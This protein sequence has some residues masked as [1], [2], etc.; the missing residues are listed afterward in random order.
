MP[1]RVV[2]RDKATGRIGT[3]VHPFEVPDLSQFRVTTPVLSDT[4]EDTEQGGTGNRLAIL[5]R[6]D[7]PEGSSLFCQVEVYGA[8]RLESSR[9]PD[10]VVV[11]DKA[12]G[13]IGT[14]VH[15]FEVPDL[16]QFRVKTPVLSDTREDTEQGGTGNRLAI[17]AR[18][19]FPEG[20]SLFCQVEVYGAARLES[21]RM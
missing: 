5:A 8:A 11:R 2:V 3:V 1:D 15:P 16:S 4:R 9:M 7:F 21:S 18:R 12:T 13:R 17:L 6:R 10:R 19:D 20:S 14:V